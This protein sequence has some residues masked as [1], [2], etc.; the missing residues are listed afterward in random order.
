MMNKT[1]LVAVSCLVIGATAGSQVKQVLKILGIG[2]V[3]KQFGPDINREINKLTKHS[4]T[5][6]SSTRVVPILRITIND[7]TAIGAAQIMGPKSKV[8]QV[9]AVAAPEG[10]FFGEITIRGLIPVSDENVL[11][12]IK[13][14]DGVAVSGIVDLKA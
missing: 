13:K 8:D 12:G 1:A 11:K 9:K 3:V 5:A 6:S 2:A 4:D 7:R 10:V 14:V